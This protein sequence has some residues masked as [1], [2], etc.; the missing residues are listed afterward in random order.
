MQWQYEYQVVVCTLSAVRRVVT[1]FVLIKMHG[2]TTIKKSVG[3]Y[4]LPLTPMCK[5]EATFCPSQILDLSLITRNKYSNCCE[6]SSSHRA[7]LPVRRYSFAVWNLVESDRDEEPITC[8]LIKWRLNSAPAVQTVQ[9]QA[10]CVVD[11]IEWIHQR[12]WE[13]HTEF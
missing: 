6:I 11:Q 9:K 8:S 3:L 5:C 4:L 12:R 7:H 13:A 1:R 10:S 2:K